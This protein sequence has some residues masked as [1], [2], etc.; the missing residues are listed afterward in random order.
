MVRP[1]PR[2]DR[3]RRACFDSAAGLVGAWSRAMLAVQ[4]VAP[5]PDDPGT[6][7]CVTCAGQVG[8]VRREGHLP[9]LCSWENRRGADGRLGSDR[10][11][12]MNPVALLGKF[13]SVPFPGVCTRGEPGYE[14]DVLDFEESS[15]SKP[16]DYFVTIRGEERAEPGVFEFHVVARVPTRRAVVELLLHRSMHL[17]GRPF[18]GAYFVGMGGLTRGEM[19]RRWF[20]RVH[21]LGV[22]EDVGAPD[23]GWRGVEPPTER[24]EEIVGHLLEDVGWNLSDFR[25]IRWD[26]AFPVWGCDYSLRVRS[27]QSPDRASPEQP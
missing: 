15:A 23:Q 14:H 7:E 8:L 19:A 27:G 12:G 6:L 25:R 24:H 20:D 17:D 18:G 4:A 1:L 13:S 2:E 10:P 21:D 16:L 22:P 26:I 11:R 3:R 9:I 5:K